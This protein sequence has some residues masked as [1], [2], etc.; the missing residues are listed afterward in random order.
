[1][2]SCCRC[3]ETQEDRFYPSVLKRGTANGVWCKA[4]HV[5]YGRKR[6]EA[7]RDHFLKYQRKRRET[8]LDQ[9][10]ALRAEKGCETCGE[11]H[12]ACLD[13][14]HRDGEQKKFSIS[15]EAAR[16]NRNL[17]YLK[18]EIAKCAI[19]CS[20]CHRKHHW[21]SRTGPYGP[22]WKHRRKTEQ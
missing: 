21:E 18:E 1:M 12:P 16:N 19:L 9:L 8:V 14:H 20:N 10:A 7:D 3:G 17:E 6:V 5:E 2:A 15:Q 13:Y 11:K 22:K 4:C